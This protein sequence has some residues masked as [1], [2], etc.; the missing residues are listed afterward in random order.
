M[1][2]GVG[3]CDYK[4]TKKLASRSIYMKVMGDSTEAN[5]IPATLSDLK[6]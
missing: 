1:E 6:Y 3:L 2:R 4:L 5:A